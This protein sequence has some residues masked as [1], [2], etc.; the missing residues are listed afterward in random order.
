M[1][2]L[3]KFLSLIVIILNCVIVIEVGFFCWFIAENSESFSTL[4]F[5]ITL[6]IN[7]SMLF[8]AVVVIVGVVQSNLALLGIWLIYAIIE[9]SRSSIVFYDSWAH[10]SE[11]IY[12][13]IFNSCDVSTQA[14]AIIVVS[15][16]FQV[17]KLQNESRSKITSINVEFNKSNYDRNKK[18]SE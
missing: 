16:L 12:E 17:V 14:I 7:V 11:N 2:K 8:F 13:I 6:F 15:M 9:L 10:P 4:D 3:K 5:S 18:L 1:C